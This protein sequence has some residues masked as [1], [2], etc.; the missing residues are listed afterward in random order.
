MVAQGSEDCW[1]C[2]IQQDTIQVPNLSQYWYIIYIYILYDI[3]IYICICKN[4]SPWLN[5][6][7]EQLQAAALH[8]NA[9][10][11]AG[12]IAGEPLPRRS[13]RFWHAACKARIED[14]GPAVVAAWVGGCKAR[15]MCQTSYQTR[16][17]WLSMWP[18]VANWYVPNIAKRATVQTHN[19]QIRTI[20]HQSHLDLPVA[21]KLESQIDRCFLLVE[22]MR[23]SN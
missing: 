9:T 2:R 19:Q 5:D 10:S 16:Y 7:W 18:I 6:M 14:E 17:Q 23:S 20:R 8:I 13:Y 15:H 4:V 21:L 1:R 12:L 11:T 3:Y 22:P